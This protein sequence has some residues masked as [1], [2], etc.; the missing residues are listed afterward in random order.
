MLQ[1]I[2]GVLVVAVADLHRAGAV[3]AVLVH[4][5]QNFRQHPGLT[6]GLE[7]EV[8]F[9]VRSAAAQHAHVQPPGDEAHHL[10]D[11]AGLGKVLKAGQRKQDV[12]LIVEL[13]YRGADLG[14]ALALS[15]EPVGQL[16]GPRQRTGAAQGIQ[17]ENL[18]FGVI[19][20]YHLPGGQR[21]VVAAR[22]VVADGQ[23]QHVV[24]LQEI[25]RPF[26]GAGTGRG[27][28][29]V[30]VRHGLQHL[31]HVQRGKI[32][33]FPAAHADLE[34][35]QRKLHPRRRGG[36]LPDLTRS[37]G[38]DHPCHDETSL[39]GS[40]PENEFRTSF[41]SYYIGPAP[42]RQ[43]ENERTVK[44]CCPALHFPCKWSII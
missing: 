9:S 8:D 18:L 27:A 12:S 21:R 1:Q 31:P 3:V 23:G 32:H 29:A 14:K 38:H 5:L 36:Q 26:L 6:A 28:G 17:N 40:K 4:L 39:S 16:G 7:E 44:P 20:Q 19:F 2:T 43:A 37:V 10:A 22:K 33:I 35:G 25:F 24:R 15:D 42:A 30:E 11:A 34:G 13:L 41:N